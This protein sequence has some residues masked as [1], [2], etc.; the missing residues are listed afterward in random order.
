MIPRDG[1]AS[2]VGMNFIIF[3]LFRIK[4]DVFS[5]VLEHYVDIHIEREIKRVK[6]GKKE[7]QT[8]IHDDMLLP[9]TILVNKSLISWN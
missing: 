8:F 7:R 6:K 2:G 5:K 1:V 9:R 3:L 4:L